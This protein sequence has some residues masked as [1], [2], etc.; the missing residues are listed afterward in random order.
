LL[1]AA[2]PG[3]LTPPS[4]ESLPTTIAQ[5]SVICIAWTLANLRDNGFAIDTIDTRVAKVGARPAKS[6]RDK[7]ILAVLNTANTWLFS[8]VL[9]ALFSSILGD[10]VNNED[11]AKV[12]AILLPILCLE[13]CVLTIR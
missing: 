8:A 5:T 13:R 10:V 4:T 3:W 9:V 11:T 12:V 7:L 1:I 6:S 2:F